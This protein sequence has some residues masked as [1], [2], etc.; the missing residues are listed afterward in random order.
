[1]EL[2]ATPILDHAAALSAA[3]GVRVT[4]TH[5]IGKA[6]ASG[7]RLVPA[8]SARV[9]FGRVVPYPQIDVGFAVDVV[10]GDDL[11]PVTLRAVDTMSVVQIAG[12]LAARSA[13]VRAGADRDFA[14]AN[15]WVRLMPGMLTRPT[16]AFASIWN[17]GLGLRAFGVAGFPLGGAF[18]S[19]V[20]SL[21]L[22]EAYLAPVPFARCP[23]YLAIGAIRE[24]PIVVAG[25]VVARPTVVLTATG[26]HR[27]VDGAHAARL[28][29]FLRT[30]LSDPASLDASQPNPRPS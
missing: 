16:L 30:A 9:V 8:V 14:A 13:R 2:D 29:N 27:I 20:G 28:A 5:V 25:Q 6:V 26:D 18:I 17:G 4:V 11:A 1:M 15:G 3:S 19:N 12:E 23:F 24:R 21:G 7:L 10:D 22:D